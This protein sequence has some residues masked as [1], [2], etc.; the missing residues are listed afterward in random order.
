MASTA[1][2]LPKPTRFDLVRL[3][4]THIAIMAADET[5]R[6]DARCPLCGCASAYVR[7]RSVRRVT[8]L[9]WHAGITREGTVVVAT[10]S[11]MRRTDEIP[12]H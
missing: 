7:S 10:A 2:V 5:M 3:P 9:P 1:T 4:A 6:P 12:A 11:R 8:D